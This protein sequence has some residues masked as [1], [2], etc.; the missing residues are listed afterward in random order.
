MSLNPRIAPRRQQA[1]AA[2]LEQLR[3][4]ASS[5][6]G[7]L[8]EAGY[9]RGVRPLFEGIRMVG[10]VLTVKVFTPDGSILRD[11]LLCSEP[12]DV[13]VIECVG[14]ADCACWGELRTLAGLIKGLA[15]V[16]VAGSVTDVAALREHGLP[17][18]SRGISALTTR[19]LGQGG[20]LNQPIRVGEVLVHPG[21]IAI[22]DDDGVFIL[23]ARQAR[24]LLP[25]LLAKESADRSRR[26]ELLAR[27][28]A[29]GT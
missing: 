11:A 3:G 19:S 6:A 7:H 16:V 10:N 8:V 5:T 27:L 22:G 28:V 14:D 20:E 12:D 15:G 21:D 13:L 18:F 26:A 29:K 2:L 24:E 17:I 9:L 23:S 1:D 4:I 25:Q